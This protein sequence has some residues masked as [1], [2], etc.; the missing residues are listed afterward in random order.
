MSVALG[1]GVARFAHVTPARR[2]RVDMLEERTWNTADP[3]ELERMA[4]DVGSRDYQCTALLGQPDYQ[5]VLVEAPNVKR[6]ELKAAVR[7]RIKDMIDFHV[8]DAT[9]DVLDIPVGAG[10]STRPASM[11]VVVTRNETVQRVVDRF[12]QA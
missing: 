9:I 5:I 2:P 8:D 12:Q 6:E 3:K 7:W 10:I 1:D 4:K 11:Y